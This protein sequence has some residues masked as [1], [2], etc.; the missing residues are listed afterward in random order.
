MTKFR[1]EK[2][3][4][5]SGSRAR[6]HKIGSPAIKINTELPGVLTLTKHSLPK[7]TR[8][9]VWPSYKSLDQILLGQ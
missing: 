2:I 7:D 9:I 1:I 8:F 6:D 3:P 4:A 5:P